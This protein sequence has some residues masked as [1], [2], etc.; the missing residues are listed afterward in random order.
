M[1]LSSPIKGLKFL[2]KYNICAKNLQRNMVT[3]KSNCSYKS[4]KIISDVVTIYRKIY[5]IL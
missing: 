4:F 5:K 3:K 1:Y 2:Q